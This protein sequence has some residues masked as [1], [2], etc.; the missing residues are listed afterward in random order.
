MKRKG[1]DSRQVCVL[2]IGACLPFMEGSAPFEH[3]GRVG[4]TLLLLNGLLAFALNVVGVFLIDSAGS[5]VLTLSGVLKVSL[6][7]FLNMAT[8]QP[9]V[10]SRI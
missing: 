10:Q 4:Y 2:V 8:S 7:S 1:T 5:L 9:F 3:I 6:L